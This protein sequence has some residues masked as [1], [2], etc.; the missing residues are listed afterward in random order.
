[1]QRS[2]ACD[3]PHHEH[4]LSAI[5]LPHGV[6]L[7]KATGN[8]GALWQRLPSRWLSN[9]RQT[10][11]KEATN[12]LTILDHQSALLNELHSV[13]GAMVMQARASARTTRASDLSFLADSV[14]ARQKMILSDLRPRRRSVAR[15]VKERLVFGVVALALA[16][17]SVWI[18]ADESAGTASLTSVDPPAAH[19]L[20][21]SQDRLAAAQPTPAIQ[22]MPGMPSWIGGAFVAPPPAI[23]SL[24]PHSGQH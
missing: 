16:G 18:I 11:D 8:K 2:L 22:S 21:K 20:E 5:A 9:N 12:E 15:R 4:F 3:L 6:R 10:T 7:R 17:L 24:Q 23:P 19:R 14:T 13:D 1:M